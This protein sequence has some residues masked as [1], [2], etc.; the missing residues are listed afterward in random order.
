VVAPS[1]P[2]GPAPPSTEEPA[3][4]EQD[5][6]VADHLDTEAF[7]PRG[8]RTSGD[9]RARCAPQTSLGFVP[10]MQSVAEPLTSETTSW[11]VVAELP[12]TGGLA[13]IEIEVTSIGDTL[14]PTSQSPCAAH[15][16]TRAENGLPGAAGAAPT[17]PSTVS[18]AARR[19]RR[20]AGRARRRRAPGSG[21][22]SAR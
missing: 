13:L 10:S 15:V 1:E 16:S 6:E 8:R 20:A 18:R 5:A 12:G 2:A 17:V 11:T 21:E 19:R 14:G 4:V 9:G 7:L 3:D 22:E